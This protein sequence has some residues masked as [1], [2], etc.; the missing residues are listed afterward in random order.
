MFDDEKLI[1]P[2]CLIHIPLSVFSAYSAD[3]EQTAA[4]IRKV[5]SKDQTTIMDPHTAVGVHCG[6]EYLQVGS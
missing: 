2:N 4:A 3:E 1:S 6:L 5:F